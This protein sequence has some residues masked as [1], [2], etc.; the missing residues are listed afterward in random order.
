MTNAE[1]INKMTNAELF[2]FMF[3]NDRCDC[4]AYDCYAYS[5]TTDYCL[6]KYKSGIRL[7]LRE[8][9]KEELI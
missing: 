7:W 6:K 1:K 2:Y 5:K 4:C 9:C 8:E 3:T